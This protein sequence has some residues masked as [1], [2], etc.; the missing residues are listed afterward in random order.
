MDE[1]VVN[2]DG[3]SYPHKKHATHY[4]PVHVW[5]KFIKY[6]E[7]PFKKLEMIRSPPPKKK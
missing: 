1:I 5:Y 4:Q 2:C 6:E 3:N 7:E